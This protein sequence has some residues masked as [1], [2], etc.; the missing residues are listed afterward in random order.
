MAAYSPS[1]GFEGDEEEC[2]EIIERVN[3]SGATVLVVGVGSPKQEKWIYEYKE[4]L[5]GIKLIFSLGATIDFEAGNLKRAPKWM[6]DCGFEWLY[7]LLCEPRR[8]WKRYLINDL[9]FFC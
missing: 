7:R 3:K 4:K 5:S 8:L 9:P 2:L 6:S 1:F